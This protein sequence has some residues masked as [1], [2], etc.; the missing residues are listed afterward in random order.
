MLPKFPTYEEISLNDYDLV[1]GYYTLG[2]LKHH[3]PDFTFITNGQWQDFNDYRWLDIIIQQELE[4]G[5]KICIV[6][7][8]ENTIGNDEAA[9]KLSK[10]LNKYIDDPVWFVTQF[11]EQD[12]KLYTFQYQLQCKI[13]ELP[14]WLLNDCLTYYAVTNRIPISL[15]IE[16][17]FLCMLGR[18]QEHKADLAYS[19]R[20]F[21]DHG[22]ITISYPT[23]YPLDT[24]SFCRKNEFD[25]YNKLSTNNEKMAAQTKIKGIW[26]SANVQNFLYI[27]QKYANIPL[28][29]HPETTC[30]IFFNTEKTLWPLLLGKL[31][32]IHGKP[33]AMQHIQRFYDVDF[34]SYCDLTFDLPPESWTDEEHLERC[35][36][37]CSKNR[38]LIVDCSNIY[39]KLHTD[40]EK[41]RWTIGKNM[42]NFF[43]TQINSL[44]LD[45]VH[46]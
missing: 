34:S 6:P 30:G 5:Q 43:I 12:Q 44:F 21:A 20:E 33:G 9:L 2:M 15:N 37:L 39:N 16:K 25:P 14:W 19:L 41:A 40:L 31:M 13:I 23:T 45:Q 18:F 36:L 8:D 17:N 24:M 42:Y 3:C 7:W 35:R 11:N 38:D 27:Q 22:I 28:M 46:K 4:K 32:L 26:V 10:V 29:I 1:D